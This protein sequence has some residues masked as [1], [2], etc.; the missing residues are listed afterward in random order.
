MR[1]LFGIVADDL[2]NNPEHRLVM[3]VQPLTADEA[4]RIK[5]DCRAFFFSFDFTKQ[6]QPYGHQI[7]VYTA[8]D[9]LQVLDLMS[10][11]RLIISPAEPLGGPPF[12]AASYG[13]PTVLERSTN[14]F[15]ERGGHLLFPE[16]LTAPKG[17]SGQFFDQLQ[18]LQTDVAF[19]QKHGRAYQSFVDS[20]ATYGAYVRKL[21]EISKKRGW[22][23]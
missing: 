18:R 14:P 21:E 2:K 10:K 4:V 9:W 3:L 23:V 1:K 8:I 19:H 16:V 7:E 15:V 17:F 12:E 13:V 11:A 6:L 22:T 5:Q 20:H